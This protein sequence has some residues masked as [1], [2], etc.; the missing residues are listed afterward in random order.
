VKE[1]I[2]KERKR[3]KGKTGVKGQI[4][5]MKMNKTRKI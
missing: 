5:E 2:E 3:R 1:E 4:E